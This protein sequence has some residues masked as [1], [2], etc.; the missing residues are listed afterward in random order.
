MTQIWK[1]PLKSGRDCLVEKA[2]GFCFDN[3]WVGVGWVIDS[4][5]DGLTEPKQYEQTLLTEE[6]GQP[7]L[8]AHY[9]L[10]HRMQDGDLVWC[11]AKNDV[12]WLGRIEGSW[13]YRNGGDFD[14]F[15]LHQ[16]RKCR[17]VRVGPADIVPGPIKNA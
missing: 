12:Y 5:P 7:A 9:A 1:M 11:R 15:D 16:V 3:G 4:I 14:Y 10:A 17:W 13:L 2:R 8:S 6:Y